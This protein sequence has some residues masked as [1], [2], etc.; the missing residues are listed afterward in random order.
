MPRHFTILQILVYFYSKQEKCNIYSYIFI[1]IL[2]PRH[3]K[4][5]RIKEKKNKIKNRNN[6]HIATMAFIETS[7]AN[8]EKKKKS[9]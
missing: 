1:Y 4:K 7:E 5:K 3:Q 2:K 9:V 8:L 6:I